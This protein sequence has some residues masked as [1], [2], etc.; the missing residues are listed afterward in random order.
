[1]IQFIL[2]DGDTSKEDTILAIG[3]TPDLVL[4]NFSWWNLRF[5]RVQLEEEDVAIVDLGSNPGLWGKQGYFLYG[6]YP[7][8]PLYVEGAEAVV[9]AVKTHLQ[10]FYDTK[11][12]ESFTDLSGLR[13]LPV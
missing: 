6:A 4:S 2:H 10:R 5:W 8:C 3:F 12:F 9:A 7:D 13:V 11:R 1:M